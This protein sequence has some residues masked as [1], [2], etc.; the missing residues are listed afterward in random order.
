MAF[1]NPLPDD[2]PEF[3]RRHVNVADPRLG[4]RVLSCSDEFFGAKERLLDPNPPTFVPGKYDQHGK[5]MDGW[6]SRRKRTPGHDWCIVRLA[7]ASRVHGVEVDTRHFTGNFP[8]SASIEAV[9]MLDHDPADDAEWTPLLPT[10]DLAGDTRLFFA[11]DS[12][13]P[14]THLRFNIYPDGGVARLR[15]FGVPQFD[16]DKADSDGL[17]D[18]S[19]ACSGGTIVASNNEHYGSS[20]NLLLPGRGVDMGDGWETRRRRE[21]GHDWCI[22]ALSRPGTIDAIDVDTAHFKG[23]YPDR[24]SFQAAL[25]EPGLTSEA[26]VTQSMSWPVLMPE[27]PLHPD[28]AILFV[29]HVADIGPVSHVRFNIYPDGGVSRLR[30]RGRPV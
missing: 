17:Y 20:S 1:P 19:A 10:V 12:E 18:L 22:V 14:V 11:I 21:P 15:V 4:A 5:W 23:N 2:A 30:L 13:R 26:L 7:R 6:E 9:W 24:C 28:K 29:E 16:V 3:A 27:Q 25:V 8:P